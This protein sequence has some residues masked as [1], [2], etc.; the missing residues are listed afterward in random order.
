MGKLARVS[1]GKSEN[2]DK[3]YVTDQTLYS[4]TPAYG[5]A[6]MYVNQMYEDIILRKK[7]KNRNTEWL[8]FSLFYSIYSFKAFFVMEKNIYS[9]WQYEI[10]GLVQHCKEQAVEEDLG[11][12]GHWKATCT[13]QYKKTLTNLWLQA[14][15]L[16]LDPLIQTF[17]MLTEFAVLIVFVLE[18]L[19]YTK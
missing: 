8:S 17:I 6:A 15:I 18:K 16:L 1:T 10:N 4:S 2:V 12:T 14:E 13:F 11:S 9:L 19:I 5:L 7:K 3:I